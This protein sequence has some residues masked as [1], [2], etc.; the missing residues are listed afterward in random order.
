MGKVVKLA[1]VGGT[2][3]PI[4]R[5]HLAVARVAQR[6]YGLQQVLFGARKSVRHRPAAAQLP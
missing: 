6:Q 1:L 4:H 5:G 2:F 3:D